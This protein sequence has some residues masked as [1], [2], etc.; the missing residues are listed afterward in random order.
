MLGKDEK[1]IFL[2]TDH[3]AKFKETV[4][5]IVEITVN[6]TENLIGFMSGTKSTIETGTSYEDFKNIL[7]ENK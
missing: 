2:E 6:I 4:E 7:L 5:E 3:P 1:G